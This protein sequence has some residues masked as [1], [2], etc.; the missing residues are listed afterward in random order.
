[1]FAELIPGARDTAGLSLRSRRP[2][3]I[4]GTPVIDSP[5]PV[6]QL[7]QF[8][9]QHPSCK[10]LRGLAWGRCAPGLTNTTWLGEAWKNHG[11][12]ICV[13][14]H[15]ALGNL[16]LPLASSL[17]MTTAQTLITPHTH[18]PPPPRPLTQGRWAE[19]S[20]EC[21]GAADSTSYSACD[22]PPWLPPSYV[23][24]S[25]WGGLLQPIPNVHSHLSPSSGP[26]K[27]TRWWLKMKFKGQ[28]WSSSGD[29]KTKAQS[30]RLL[31]ILWL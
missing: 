22:L 1:V 10:P 20:Q 6:F 29:H 24:K 7:S 9:C 5:H 4:L 14:S 26:K 8:S 28:S 25:V 2:A 13:C 16:S 18:R 27:S 21:V 15:P 23:K 30:W 31:V 19:Q 17:T 12:H 3:H 11:A